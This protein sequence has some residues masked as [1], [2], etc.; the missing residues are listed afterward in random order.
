MNLSDVY[1]TEEL[2]RRRTRPAD[3]LGEKSA[4]Q[5]LAARMVDE[6]EA[7]L[8]RFVELAMS[9]TGGVSAGLSLLEPTPV[10]AVFRWRYLQGRLAAFENATTPRD[11]SRSMKIST[12]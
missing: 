1:I 3:Y 7:V 12:T 8:P 11:F 4:L 10:P 5:D 9:M 6:P 2:V